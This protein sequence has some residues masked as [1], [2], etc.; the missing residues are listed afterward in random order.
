MHKVSTGFSCSNENEI[1]IDD[2]LED[3]MNMCFV[4]ELHPEDKAP[5]ISAV[6]LPLHPIAKLED[7]ASDLYKVFW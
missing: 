3:D 2:I 6:E 5:V 7:V 4:V 1:F